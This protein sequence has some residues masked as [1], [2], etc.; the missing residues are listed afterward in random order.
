MM[1]DKLNEHVAVN[2]KPYVIPILNIH[3]CMFTLE[4]KFV[5]IVAERYLADNVDQDQEA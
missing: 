5:P 4:F 2:S 1:I 3:Q